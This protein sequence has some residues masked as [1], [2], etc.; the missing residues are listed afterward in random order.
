VYKG[1]IVE[2]RLSFF[3]NHDSGFDPSILGK[4]DNSDPIWIGAPAL[5]VAEAAFWYRKF[6]SETHTGQLM[7]LRT[8]SPTLFFH[9]NRTAPDV[10]GALGIIT[11]SLNT[12]RLLL[13]VVVILAILSF[14]SRWK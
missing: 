13:W 6:Y 4:P 3:D 9:D 7:T 8:D 11:R 10:M 14:L 5:E 1:R 2:E 12:V